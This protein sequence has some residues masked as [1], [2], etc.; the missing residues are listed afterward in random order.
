MLTR[1]CSNF[2]CVKLTIKSNA[3]TLLL[4]CHPLLSS[5]LEGQTALSKTKSL[6]QELN[7]IRCLHFLQQL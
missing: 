1:L 7:L 5:R 4:L 2:E 3:P 6:N